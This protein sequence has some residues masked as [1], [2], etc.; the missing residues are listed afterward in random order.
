VSIVDNGVRRRIDDDLGSQS[1]T[2]IRSLPERVLAWAS[3]SGSH[4][5][6]HRLDL[7]VDYEALCN[8]LVEQRP[9]IVIHMAEQRS[10][11]YSMLSSEGARYSID[12]N[13]RGTH[14]LLA[15]MVETG[16]SPHLIHLGTIGVY[17]YGSAGLRLP[18][19]YLRVSARGSDGRMVDKEIIYPG[20]P[21][22][23]Y[24][25]TKALDQQL[26]A[27]Y[28]RSYGLRITDLHQGIVWGTQSTETRRDPL[29]VNR[30]DHDTI[31]GTVVNRFLLQ[32]LGGRPLTVYGSGNQTRAFIHI[33]DMLT[34][35]TL[36]AANPPEAH[37]RTRIVNQY[38][39]IATLN[40]LAAQ[41]AT[42]T[43][44]TITHRQSRN[45]E[46]EF[47]EFDVDRTILTG[48]DFAPQ[49]F[50]DRMAD[51]IRDLTDLLGVQPSS[52]PTQLQP[53]L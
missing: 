24:H 23:V 4:I 36:A 6:L 41:I 52:A 27:F 29:L 11:P 2:P 8:L 43:G 7:A 50:Q 20:E 19:G 47:N 16:L 37:Q 35:I 26:F 5:N 33:E 22:S 12:N 9:D 45:W 28:A 18:E 13:V 10:A 46:P 38:S 48:L 40:E 49:T 14:N 21:D 32:A 15:A 39:Q 25:L 42:L 34:C 1:V 51:E 30:F 3:E 53:D 44:A 17:G 31:Y